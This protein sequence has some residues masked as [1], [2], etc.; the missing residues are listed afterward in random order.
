MFPGQNVSIPQ[1]IF[2]VLHSSFLTIHLEY[3]F[4]FPYQ[5]VS[6]YKSKTDLNTTSVD[7]LLGTQRSHQSL[8]RIMVKTEEYS[9]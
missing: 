3:I 8:W 6:V 5:Y 9:D 2:F 1:L 7:R 4:P